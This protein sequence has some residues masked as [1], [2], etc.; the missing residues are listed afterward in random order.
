MAL[1]TNRIRSELGLAAIP[2]FRS[3]WSFVLYVVA[4]VVLMSALAPPNP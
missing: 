1:V 3:A 4:F 2:G